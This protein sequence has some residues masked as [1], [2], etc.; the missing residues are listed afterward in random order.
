MEE[1]QWCLSI[2]LLMF[3]I[4]KMC[5]Y[6]IRN[7]YNSKKVVV[8]VF[9]SICSGQLKEII[10]QSKTELISQSCVWRKPEG[11]LILAL[12]LYSRRRP[13][14]ERGIKSVK[15]HSGEIHTGVIQGDISE[16][17]YISQRR[18]DFISFH[19]PFCWTWQ[20]VI[21]FLVKIPA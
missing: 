1:E 14:W 20:V 8:Y 10:T 5:A 15:L 17:S 7:A 4:S 19:D 12:L 13:Q 18:A 11:G 2:L 3:S 9:K 16:Q 21:S 6:S